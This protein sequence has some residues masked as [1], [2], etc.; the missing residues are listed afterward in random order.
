MNAQQQLIRDRAG[1]RCEY[2]KLSAV[3][4]LATFHFDHVHPVSRGGQD[5][6]DNRA[7]ACPSCNLS[8]SNRLT[9]MDPETSI[10]VPIFNPRVHEWHDHFRFDG[11]TLVGLTPIGRALIGALELNSEQ[12]L[13]VRSVEHQMGLFPL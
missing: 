13:F 6:S 3:L 10:E 7:F 9:L 1:N 8:K 5:N 2:C 4:Q 11:Y 12:Y